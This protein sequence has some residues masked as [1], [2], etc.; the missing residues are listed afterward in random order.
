MAGRSFFQRENELL[1]NELRVIK[2]KIEYLDEQIRDLEKKEGFEQE[3]KKFIRVQKSLLCRKRSLENKLFE[4]EWECS[5]S[6]SK[7]ETQKN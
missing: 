7:S 5:K 1:K 3:T 6:K 4:S 2:E